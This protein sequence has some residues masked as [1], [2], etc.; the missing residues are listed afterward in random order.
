[1]TGKYYL[2]CFEN[3]YVL[4]TPK[5]MLTRDDTFINRNDMLRNLQEIAPSISDDALRFELETYFRDIL[6]KKKKE[7]SQT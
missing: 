6:A 2:P 5:D 4:L 1:M 7:M 3:D